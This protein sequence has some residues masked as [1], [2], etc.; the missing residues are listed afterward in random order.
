M[1]AVL[2]LLLVSTS[3]VDRES[4]IVPFRAGCGEQDARL[5]AIAWGK[6]NGSK[7]VEY[8]AATAKGTVVARGRVETGELPA[9]SLPPFHDPD[10]EVVTVSLT[11]EQA[12]IV[13]SSLN[14]RYLHQGIDLNVAAAVKAVYQS[15]DHQ[16]YGVR[17]SREGVQEAGR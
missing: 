12:R 3:H 8:T 6:A 1:N 4:Q 10:Q 16:V 14:S 7:A 13:L 9:D 15:I 17:L 5:A 2:Y 11:K